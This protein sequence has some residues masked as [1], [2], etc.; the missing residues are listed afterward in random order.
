MKHRV[1]VP[2]LG[3]TS[4][5]SSRVIR[6]SIKSAPA[7]QQGSF[8]FPDNCPDA[9]CQ[10]LVTYQASGNNSVVFELRGRGN[11]AGVGFSD[12]NQ[13]ADT[14]ILICASNTS[15]SGHYY[16]TSRT[17]PDRTDPTPS[18]VE[19]TNQTFNGS[20]V[21]CRITRELDPGI[22]NFRN[23]RQDWFLL[24]AI[25]DLTGATIGIHSARRASSSR[26]N[27]LTGEV[28]S[29]ATVMPT[30]SSST[31][32]PTRQQGSFRFPDNCPD[33]DCDFLVT[34]QASGA[35]SL[36]LKC[37]SREGLNGVEAPGQLLPDT[38]ILICASDTSLS[39]HYYATGR[40]TPARTDP[41]PPAV[42]I[43]DQSF[44]G[45]VVSCR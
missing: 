39:G 33:A 42:E 26:I 24:G 14:D 28:G 1:K 20:V 5:P 38:D 34:Y 21:S 8:R 31:E 6:S 16:A 43:A 23:L 3:K 18:A 36:L 41:T 13:M 11:W 17:T 25:G 27:V 22:A 30:S 44:N 12:D 35:N 2:K 19:I 10:F 45:G 9:D 7:M 32:A 37:S 4:K 29:G 40:S 15:L